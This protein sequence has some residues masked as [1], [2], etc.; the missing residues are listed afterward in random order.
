[1]AEVTLARTPLYELHQSLGAKLTAF[2]GYDMPVQYPAGIIA[3][4]LHTRAKASLF[5]VSHMGQVL[6]HGPDIAARLE[7]LV[8]SD[9][10]G[11]R[12][13][14]LRYTVLTNERGGIIDDLMVGKDGDA[15]R[16]V[17]NAACKA[18]DLAHLRDRLGADAVTYLEDR[19]LLALQGPEAAAVL[20][21]L[22]HGVDTLAFMAAAPLE[23]DGIACDVT[24]SGY[25]GEDGFEISLPAADAEHLARRLLAE[26]E[27]APAGLGARDTLRLEAGLCLYGADIDETTTPVEADLAWVIPARRRADGG[28][29]GAA[30]I[31]RQLA[32]GAARRRVGIKPEG[33]QIARGHTPIVDAAGAAIGVI[34]SGGFSPSLE[35][36]IAMGYVPSALAMPGSALR[37]S[38][39]GAERPARVAALPFVPHR[40]HTSR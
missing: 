22:A 29:P 2:A 16:L 18:G 34:T 4:H 6:L 30:I 15:L 14:R 38:V 3:E 23:L 39:R 10:V 24:R 13:G 40:Y 12:P 11:L 21:R 32:E 31:A 8:P 5:D 20:G 1:M 33:R 26:A 25:T 7:R 28:Y 19:A 17:V 36:A 27:V 9:I 37:L 35:T